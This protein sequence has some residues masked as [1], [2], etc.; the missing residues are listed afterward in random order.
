MLG[1]PPILFRRKVHFYH[2]VEHDDTYKR[3]SRPFKAIKD[4]CP[5]TI[6]TLD[7][8]GLGSDEGIKIVNLVDWL[9]D[10]K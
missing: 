9:L 4:N 8:F 5:K 6:L 7:R 3:E 2:R 10:K 1:A